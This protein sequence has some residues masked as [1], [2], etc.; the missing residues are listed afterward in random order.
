MGLYI[1]P[2]H[3]LGF[4][5]IWYDKPVVIYEDNQPIIRV[6]N[7][8]SSIGDAG[9]HMETRVEHPH[10]MLGVLSIESGKRNSQ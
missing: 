3:L 10:F 2:G 1:S 5:G 4:A 8:E 7:N 9:R 6:A